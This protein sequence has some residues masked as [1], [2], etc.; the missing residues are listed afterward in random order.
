MQLIAPEDSVDQIQRRL[1]NDGRRFL[2]R[3]ALD[4][5]QDFYTNFRFVD[6]DDDDDFIVAVAGRFGEAPERRVEIAL[7]RSC[8]LTARLEILL[9]YPISLRCLF[10]KN[11]IELC[12]SPPDADQFFDTL[13]SLRWF[14]RYASTSPIHCSVR[15]QGEDEM[16]EMF[17]EIVPK[18]MDALGPH[19]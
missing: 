17:C 18:L 2:L 9:R 8:G 13:R 12:D 4:A 14:R 15:W 6:C 16:A 19:L 11:V 1:P 7:Y 10:L 3:D 5:L